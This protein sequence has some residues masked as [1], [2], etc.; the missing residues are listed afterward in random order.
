MRAG[1]KRELHE[2]FSKKDKRKIINN[3]NSFCSRK[4]ILDRVSHTAAAE[5]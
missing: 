2:D 5:V 1:V 3:N 4:L